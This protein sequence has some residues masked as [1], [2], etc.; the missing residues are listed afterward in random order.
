MSTFR[1]MELTDGEV[2]C[3]EIARETM[4]DFTA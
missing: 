1:D 2:T 3:Q 4:E